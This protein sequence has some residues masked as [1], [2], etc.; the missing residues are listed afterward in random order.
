MTNILNIK[1]PKITF[2]Q[3]EDD[4]YQNGCFELSETFDINLIRNK[5]ML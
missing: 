3:N 1:I 4:K 2:E 5:Y